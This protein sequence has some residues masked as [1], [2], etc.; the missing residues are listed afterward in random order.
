MMNRWDTLLHSSWLNTLPAG[1]SHTLLAQARAVQLRAGALLHAKDDPCSGLYGIEKGVIEI[2]AVNQ[3]GDHW[4]VTHLTP[5]A[6]FGEI[7][8]LDGGVRTHDAHAM[9]DC[10]LALIDNPTIHTLSQHHPWLQHALVRL[11]CAHVRESFTAIDQFL[12]L[13][14]TQ[15]LARRLL[16]LHAQSQSGLVQINQETLGKLVGLSRQSV[17]RLLAQWQ[18]AGWIKRGYATLTVVDSEQLLRL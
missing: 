8:V 10:T 7:A 15:R 13:S 17:N 6:W 4:V 1:A 3:D 12:L 11:L 5:G 16:Q 18:Q 9:S 2:S 14:P